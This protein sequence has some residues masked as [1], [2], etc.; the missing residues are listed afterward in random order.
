MLAEGADAEV[1]GTEVV[2][3]MADAVGFV[4]GDEGDGHAAQALQEDVGL[5]ALRG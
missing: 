3:P 4:H 2:T 5:D 1:G